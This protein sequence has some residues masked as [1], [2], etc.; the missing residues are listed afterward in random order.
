MSNRVI[1]EYNKNAKYPDSLHHRPSTKYPEYIFEELMSE[2]NDVYEMVRNGLYRMGLDRDNF[3]TKNWNPFAN[4]VNPGDNVLIKPNFVMHNNP[5]G[6]GTQCLYTQVSVIA[7]IID[8]VLI[9]LKGKGKIVIGDAPMQ[10]CKFNILKEESGIQALVDFY[11]NKGVDI[12]L[13]DFR[14]LTSNVVNGIHIAQINKDSKG[15]VIDL[16]KSSAFGCYDQQHMKRTRITNYNP[17]IL[18]THHDGVKNEYY[19]SNYVLEAD[20][21]INVPKPKTHRKAGVTIA[22]KNLV[23][24]NVR[25]EYLP[26]HTLGSVSE[27]GDEYKTPN[28]IRKRRSYYLDK[29]NYYSAKEQYNKAHFYKYLVRIADILLYFT[30]NK[31]T[32][33]SWSGNNTISKTIADLNKI[34]LY[35]D[36]NGRMCE[37]VQRKVFIVADMIISGEKEGPVMPSAKQVGIIAM[38]DNPYYF[39]QAIATLMGADIRK[40]PTLSE[41]MKIK[42]RYEI[43]Q[44]EKEAFLISNCESWNQKYISDLDRDSLLYYVPTSGWKEAFFIQKKYKE[45][46]LS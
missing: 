21:V 24:I 6:E 43:I 7:P 2:K 37:S 4:Y 12:S 15:T 9:A 30:G 29:L 27:G 31:Y 8:Y 20:V 42:E 16:G 39:D 40:I 41:M 33:G 23:G 38:G 18:Q 46:V 28:W 10:E 32:E 5:S 22:L 1:I 17:E 26:H 13:V 45:K 36:K 34:L 35:A 25:K 19:V 14:E 44:E 3:N 11:L